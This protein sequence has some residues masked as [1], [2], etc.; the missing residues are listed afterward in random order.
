[1]SSNVKSSS[2]DIVA[3]IESG[4]DLVANAINGETQEDVVETSKDNSP[5]FKV[6]D[7]K[8]SNA[9]NN[10]N[11]LT[12]DSGTGNPV[13]KTVIAKMVPDYSEVENTDVSVEG[14][15]DL[16]VNKEEVE[17]EKENIES[18]PF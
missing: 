8:P 6:S 17:E 2:A 11:M 3:A 18:N 5:S 10:R 12:T 9:L 14:E 4:S 13:D 7:T 1:L 15:V 16:E